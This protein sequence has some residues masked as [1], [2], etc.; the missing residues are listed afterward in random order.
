MYLRVR[1]FFKL[2][3]HV[4]VL[5]VRRVQSVTRYSSLFQ[6]L[7]HLLFGLFSPPPLPLLLPLLLP[8][9]PP[10]PLPRFDCLKFICFLFLFY[11]HSIYF[12][13]LKC[14][15]FML[16]FRFALINAKPEISL[17]TGKSLIQPQCV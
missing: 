17:F 7:L 5:S 13:F 2:H 4:R 11:L 6:V 3:F 10:P 15:V 9:P 12:L 16:Y 8:P 1:A 14:F